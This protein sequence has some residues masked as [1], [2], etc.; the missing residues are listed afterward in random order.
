NGEA[1]GSG[2]STQQA[3][4]RSNDCDAGAGAAL[5]G[6]SMAQRGDSVHQLCLFVGAPEGRGF[7]VSCEL[8]TRTQSETTSF[9]AFGS[10]LSA[11]PDGSLHYADAVV[12]GAPETDVG[13]GGLFVIDRVGGV[14]PL[15]VPGDT[16]VVP[17][18][19]NLG[20]SLATAVSA[21]G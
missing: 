11:V 12:V 8:P 4:R 19:A 7:H 14:I 2:V 5:A 18:G 10:A 16:D 15:P 21:E 20:A 3:C 1:L 13:R 6:T 9:A 17:P